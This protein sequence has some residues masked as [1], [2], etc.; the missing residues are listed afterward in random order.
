MVGNFAVH[1]NE[2]PLWEGGVRGAGRVVER[3][4]EDRAGGRVQFNQHL[5]GKHAVAQL[6][7]GEQGKRGVTQRQHVLLINSNGGLPNHGSILTN[8]FTHELDSTRHESG[9]LKRQLRR[10]RLA[11]C[12]RLP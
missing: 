3:V 11:L 4:H 5:R 6:P 10:V 1:N 7:G 12:R 8:I 2:E 9:S